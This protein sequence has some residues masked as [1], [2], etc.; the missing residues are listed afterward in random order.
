MILEMIVLGWSP[1]VL[2]LQQQPT[3]GGAGQPGRG[4]HPHGVLSSCL[5]GGRRRATPGRLRAPYGA[6]SAPSDDEASANAER[7][8][9]AWWP[10]FHRL[11]RGAAWHRERFR[12]T[13]LTH[14]RRVPGDAPPSEL[15]CMKRHSYLW[16]PAGANAKAVA[17]CSGTWSA[18]PR[19]L[20]TKDEAEICP[21][22]LPCRRLREAEDE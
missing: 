7:S 1:R 18:S 10:A 13:A 17:C 14:P 8:G 19:E 22:W 12:S 4:E 11:Q 6:E 16:A 20:A 3:G 15:V 5:G 2:R 9:A 21:I